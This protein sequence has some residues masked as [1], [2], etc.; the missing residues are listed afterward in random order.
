MTVSEVSWYG[1]CLAGEAA[2]YWANITETNK[3][4]LRIWCVYVRKSCDGFVF[5]LRL[6]GT[7]KTLPTVLCQSPPVSSSRSWIRVEMRTTWSISWATSTAGRPP[8]SRRGPM[9]PKI[10]T[11]KRWLLLVRCPSSG[12]MCPS[13][14]SAGGWKTGKSH[15][16]KQMFN[17]VIQNVIKWKHCSSL[18]WYCCH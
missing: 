15:R 18:S 12:R 7:T 4:V 1:A 14:L 6:S 10:L 8:W 5:S 13:G 3:H 9:S 17:H 11:G 16:P 2:A